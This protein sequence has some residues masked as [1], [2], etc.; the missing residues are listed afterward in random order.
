MLKGN[1]IFTGI[2]VVLAGL[3]AATGACSPGTTVTVTVTPPP[4]TTET[5][6]ITYNPTQLEYL[7][8]DRFPDYFW[9]DPDFYPVARPGAELAAAQDQFPSIMADQEEFQAILDYLNMDNKQ[10]YTHEEQLLVYRQYKK[11]TIA[12]QFTQSGSIYD[13][14][15]RTGENQGWKY[16]GTIT[17]GGTITI[18]SKEAS[19]NTC[20]ICLSKGTMI[21]T[22][23]GP[24]PVETLREGT[25]VWSMEIS[26]NRVAEPVVKVSQTEVPEQWMMVKIMLSDGRSVTASPGHPSADGRALGEYLAGEILD[27]SVI[28]SVEYLPY[29]YATTFDLLPGGSTGLYWANSILLGSTLG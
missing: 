19:F 7:V 26:G 22:P 13:F 25:V 27:R 18:T 1:R 9:C 3:T 16:T 8:F 12:L 4:T 23:E 29:E 17:A 28:T 2:I 6:T 14:V 15:I 21:D 5:S 10:S 24:M 20:P 11:L